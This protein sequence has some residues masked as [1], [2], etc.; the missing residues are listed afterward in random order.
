MNLGKALVES[1]RNKCSGSLHTKVKQFIKAPQMEEKASPFSVVTLENGAIGISYNLFHRDS[2]EME[3]YMRWDENSIIGK[4]AH[5]VMEQFLSDDELE[6]TVGLAVLNALS[7]EYMR[8]HP[9]A[10]H[11]DFETGIMDLMK[12]DKSTRV[13]LVGYFYPMI[14]KL[15]SRVKEVIVLEK[16]ESLLAGTYPFTMTG[17]PADLEQCDRVLITATTVLNDTLA[18]LLHHCTSAGF[19]GVMGPT[20]GFLP[21]V[22]F[23]LGVHAVGSTWIDDPELFLKRFA[24]GVKWGDSTRKV[25]I[26]REG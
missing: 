1:V 3:R 2:L 25:W 14:D 4:E 8:K 21:D 13:G 23:D 18:G 10:Y 15:M 6:K 17:D 7:Q 24:G 9:E 26:L 19:V 16:E 12:P 20:A 5:V 11:L 22:F